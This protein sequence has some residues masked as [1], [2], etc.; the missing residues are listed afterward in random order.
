MKDI[1]SAVKKYRSLIFDAE[2]YIWN[3]PETGYKEFKTAAYLEEQF[4]SLG[5]ELTKADGI[6]GFY[7]VVDTGKEGP[8]ILVFGELDSV[9][10]EA[11]PEADKNTGAVHSCGHNAQCAALLG[12]A[13]ALTD[14]NLTEGLCGR[15]R[16][17]AVPAEELLEI[18]YRTQL[19]ADGKIKYFGGKSEFL[20]RGLFD[21]V[22]MALMIHTSTNNTIIRGNN[23]CIAKRIIYKGKAA[24]AGGSPQQGINALYAANCGINAVN[25]I[26]ETFPDDDYIRFHPIVTAGGNMVNAIPNEVILES[27]VRGKSYEAMLRENAKVNRALCG[28]AISIGANI[29]IIDI[30]GYS[31]LCND[32]GMMRIAKR[33]FEI[34][35]PGENINYD[36]I[37]YSRGSTDLGDLS[38][39]MPVVHPYCAGQSG[40]S[41]G[42]DFYIT[43]PE[44]A[45]VKSA[46]WQLGILKL[47]LCDG[48]AEAKR[49]I[50]EFKPMF[51]SK[52]D[53]FRYVD[54]ISRDGD[55]II[56]HD[57]GKIEVI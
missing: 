46:I 28:G 44:S 19:K 38:C 16:L 2:R 51:D 9:I 24:H 33:A 35:F 36:E 6:T 39:I 30:P 37:Y 41:H 23:G 14:K 13:A 57:D 1:I 31:P 3:N 29:E 26:R 21:G 22:D 5:Y 43:D 34:A 50:S 15:I 7:T 54:E 32:L 10:C 20:Y 11:H 56:Y 45:C 27:Y 53:Y 49:I 47:L 4:R 17:C 40:T 18:G 8:E 52:E 12:I 55:R 48:G 42:S 25:A